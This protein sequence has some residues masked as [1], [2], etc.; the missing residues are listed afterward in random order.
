MPPRTDGPL[1]R[2][3]APP[4]GPR[5]PEPTPEQVRAAGR[6]GRIALVTAVLAPFVALVQV[7]LSLVAGLALA[8]VAIVVGIRARRAA[9]AAQR[10]EAVGVVAVVVGSI[11]L[12]LVCVL[13]GFFLVFWDQVS[14]YQDCQS[15]ANTRVAE[16]AC[17]E[18]LSDAILPGGSR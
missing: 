2:P 1:N 5:V 6:L 3:W 13:G 9:A 16:Q 4:G 11:G 18:K 12:A 8:L 10:G 7:P 15:G 17:Y 14:D